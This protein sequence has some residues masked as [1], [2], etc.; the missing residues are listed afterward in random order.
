MAR[1]EDPGFLGRG[2]AFPVSLFDEDG[3]ARM[4]SAGEDIAESLRILIETRPGERIMQP[5]YG[6]R[7]HDYLF[8]PMS[9]ETR[10]AMQVAIRRA[11]QFFE[12]R[13]ELH[14]VTV[15]FID[16]G[17][18]RL[19]VELAYSVIETNE[20]HNLVFPYYLTEGTLVSGNSPVR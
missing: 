8:D 14:E 16:P 3:S 20:R 17:A 13:I 12:P 4:V 15:A 6:C 7:I 11:V 2:W 10:T 5:D 18:G 19:Q 1:G 9:A